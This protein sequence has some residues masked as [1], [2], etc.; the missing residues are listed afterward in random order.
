MRKGAFRGRPGRRWFTRVRPGTGGSSRRGPVG[1]G[2]YAAGQVRGDCSGC[3]GGSHAADM[4]AGGSQQMRPGRRRI[5]R[6]RP[7]AG[8]SLRT[9]PMR[10]RVARARQG[11]GGGD[12]SRCGLVGGGS[13]AVGLTRGEQRGRPG[14]GAGHGAVIAGA[15]ASKTAVHTSR[16]SAHCLEN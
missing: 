3:G 9:P 1:G 5:A 4:G 10:R 12:R 13:Y 6:G 11:G 15:A 16:V 7:G 2:S 14:R 8:G